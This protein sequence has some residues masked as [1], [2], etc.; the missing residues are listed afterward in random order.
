M[1]A[2]RKQR[3]FLLDVYFGLAN[4]NRAKTLCEKFARQCKNYQNLKELGSLSSVLLD[5]QPT[6]FSL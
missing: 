2:L 6:P 4:D 3:S 5:V 1:I